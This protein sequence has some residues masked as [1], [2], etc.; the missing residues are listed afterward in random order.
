MSCPACGQIAHSSLSP[1]VFTHPAVQQF[2]RAHP[3]HRLRPE[4]EIDWHGRPALVLPIESVTE[5]AGIDIVCAADTMEVL[6]VD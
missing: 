3:R 4:D 6:Y 5:Q 2:K 1:F